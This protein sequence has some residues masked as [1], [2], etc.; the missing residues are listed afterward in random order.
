MYL[1]D[2]LVGV[3]LS[4]NSLKF[5]RN[6]VLFSDFFTSLQNSLKNKKNPISFLVFFS[7]ATKAENLKVQTGLH[8]SYEVAGTAVS[9]GC[10]DQYLLITISIIQT[11]AGNSV[12]TPA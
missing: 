6:S 12:K 11:S 3:F 9:I 5:N 10:H 1:H 7:R 2:E 8:N 4:I